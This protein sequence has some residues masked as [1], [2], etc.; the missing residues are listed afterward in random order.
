MRTNEILQWLKKQTPL[1]QEKGTNYELIDEHPDLL[2]YPPIRSY[3]GKNCQLTIGDLHGN[4]LKLLYFLVREGILD[5]SPNHY[6]MM[7]EIYQK[8]INALT[9]TDLTI[10]NKILNEASFKKLPKHILIRLLGDELADRGNND[11]FVLKILEK[12]AKQD[13]PFEI[14]FSNHGLEFIKVYEKGLPNNQSYLEKS[15]KK[16]ARSLTNLRKL[17]TKQLVTMD[18]IKYLVQN[19]YL[20]FI[21]ILSCSFQSAPGMLDDIYN[22]FFNEPNDSSQEEVH[23]FEK[24]NLTFYSHAP[25]GFY[26]VKSL[27]NTMNAAYHDESEKSLAKTVKEINDKFSKAVQNNKVLKKFGVELNQPFPA[28]NIPL[29]Y[30]LLRC[31][32]SRGRQEYDPPIKTLNRFNLFYVHGHDGNG[33]VDPEY[34]DYVTNLD[35]KFGK[36]KGT[37]TQKYSILYSPL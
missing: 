27:A 12:L 21:K 7:V 9:K 26:T 34:K 6:Q 16:Y 31:I 3:P 14:L 32:W 8:N 23:Q 4:A 28:N 2:H 20:P 1:F 18:E 5:M 10:F 13:I 15:K 36:R 30:P 17:L 25:I 37:E 11:Y 24:A 22:F 29:D 35:N 33:K 19:F